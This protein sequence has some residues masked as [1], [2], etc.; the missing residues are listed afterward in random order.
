VLNQFLVEPA[1]S[2][3]FD[4]RLILASSMIGFA[5]TYSDNYTQL[6]VKETY[7]GLSAGD[8]DF[9]LGRKMVR[10][11]TGYAFTAAGV[12]DPP[13]IPT[14][15]TD[16]LNLN[17]GRDMVKADWV[18]GPHAFS[19]AW[20]T[21]ALAPASTNLRDTTAFRY[22][23]LVRGFDTALIAGN[24]RGGDSFGALTFT[25]VLGQAWEVHGEAVWREEA[26]L[27][28]GAKYTMSGVTFIGEF[29]TPPNIPYYSY[30]GISPLAGRQ[31]YAFLTIGKARLREHPGWKEWSLSGSVV[32]N[33]DD[34]SY[35]P[36][37]D[38][39]RWFGNH[40]SSYVHVDIPRGTKT[41]E[42]GAAPYSAAT[43]VGVRFQL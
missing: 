39:S 30:M 16:R 27:V 14:N 28:L 12:L 38:G 8:F 43:S 17:E 42:Y 2:Y 18:R 4:S 40:F 35:T 9:T 31:H 3:R 33:L 37:F 23:V 1:V 15:P 13:R 11:G 22:N 6:R 34:R 36:I 24:D 25:R 29:Y 19:L 41:S 21:A 10:W 7:A 26:A 20:S 32:A 5:G